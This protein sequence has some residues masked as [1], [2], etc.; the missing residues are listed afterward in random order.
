MEHILSAGLYLARNQATIVWLSERNQGV[1]TDVLDI[2]PNEEASTQTIALQAA[3]ALRQRGIAVEQTYVALDGGYYTQ[4]N[5]HSEFTDIRQIESTIK[6][7]AEDAAATDVM[8]LAV[9]FAVTG[10]LPTGS[11]VMAF[12]ADR[13]SAT[14]ILLDLQEGGLDP[15]MIEPD[16]VCLGR[17]LEHTLHISKHP[18]TLYILINEQNGYFIQPT[19]DGYA[20]KLR[21]F[22]LGAHQQRT[23]ALRRELLLS[24]AGWDGEQ[25]LEKAVFVHPPANVDTAALAEQTGLTLTVESALEKLNTEAQPDANV[26]PEAMLIAAGAAMAPVER[27]LSAD[28]RKDFMPFQGKRKMM[29]ASLRL[30][31]ISLTVLFAALGIFFQSRSWRMNSYADTLRTKMVQEYQTA[32][33]GANPPTQEAITS[34]LRRT[35]NNARRV[36][37]GLGPGDDQSVPAKLTFLL[38]AINNSPQSVDVV[39]QQIVISERTMRVRGDTNSRRATLDLFESVKA[40][41]RLRFGQER[42]S[43]AGGRDTFEFT[44]EPAQ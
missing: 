37:E 40:H 29:E 6:F 43:M 12:S 16:A 44:V 38:E 24:I 5:L 11:E 36:K 26:C 3:R 10:L 7:D 32:M 35:L 21:S 34:R 30:V 13:Q 15:E 23:A 41:P 27:G 2:R 22:L 8:N 25:P 31:C 28:F 17:V 14:D 4:Y 39:I 20:P 18:D 9:T 33:Y 1:I 42:M 19:R